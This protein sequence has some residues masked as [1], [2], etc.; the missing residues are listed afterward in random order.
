M[1]PSLPNPASWEL[2]TNPKLREAAADQG[3]PSALQ[4][5]LLLLAERTGLTLSLDDY[6]G[7]FE[8]MP[9]LRLPISFQRHHAALCTLA[10]STQKG[11]AACVLHKYSVVSVLKRRRRALC[12]MCPW[13][14]IECA[15]PITYQGR[16]V[17]AL[18]YGS[19]VL[20]RRQCEAQARLNAACGRLAVPPRP[21]AEAWASLPCLNLEQLARLKREAARCRLVIE[22]LIEAC[23][24]PIL[25]SSAYDAFHDHQPY[26]E[27]VRRA[28]AIIHANPAAPWSIK[29]LAGRLGCHPDYLG[30]TFQRATGEKLVAFVHRARVERAQALLR[31]GRFSIA[32]VARQCG[33]REAS[34]FHRVFRGVAGLPPGEFARRPA[35]AP[36]C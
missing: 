9:Q 22:G 29:T 16:V 20:R 7:V 1:N 13:G 33:F 35:A 21:H 23:N 12:G 11:L 34:H 3:P 15:E 36:K 31:T 17:A 19:F 25:Q 2:V 24:P 30:R 27:L 4:H 32:D 18:F 5:L 8:A 26:P 10:K 6:A 28:M 14:L